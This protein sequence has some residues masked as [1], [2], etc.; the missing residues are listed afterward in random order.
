M[1]SCGLQVLAD[2][3]EVDACRTQTKTGAEIDSVVFE[4]G[5][6]AGPDRAG[7]FESLRKS[8]RARRELLDA[9]AALDKASDADVKARLD[10]GPAGLAAAMSEVLERRGRTAL[11][12]YLRNLPAYGEIHR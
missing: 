2:S 9:M 5:Q 11:R 1:L 12:I 10:A 7:V 3:E 4:D 8:S 6:F